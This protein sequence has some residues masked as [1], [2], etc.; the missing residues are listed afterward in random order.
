MSKPLV[1]GQATQKK[2]EWIRA[3]RIYLNQRGIESWTGPE[4]EWM[5]WAKIRLA[6]LSSLTLTLEE[7]SK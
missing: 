2:I 7:L 1:K 3:Q 4:L 6:E 5:K